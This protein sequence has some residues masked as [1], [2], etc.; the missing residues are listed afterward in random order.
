MV[1]LFYSSSTHIVQLP[2]W[3]KRIIYIGNIRESLNWKS[4]KEEELSFN[5]KKGDKYE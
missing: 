4:E 1:V 5:R 3:Q 2:K